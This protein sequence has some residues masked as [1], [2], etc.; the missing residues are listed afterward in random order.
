MVE[1]LIQESQDQL[2]DSDYARWKALDY[3]VLNWPYN[4]YTFL[5]GNGVPCVG[6][7]FLK[8]IHDAADNDIYASDIGLFGTFYHYG[9]ILFALLYT[10]VIRGLKRYNPL[11]L[12]FFALWFILVPTI[13]HFGLFFIATQLKFSIFIYLV[14]YYQSL[15][16]L[17]KHKEIKE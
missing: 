9:F 15:H 17:N 13:H 3:L 10:F 4:I 16:K 11:Y 14:L 6:S 5:F 8:I 12:R 1:G 7:S 2:G